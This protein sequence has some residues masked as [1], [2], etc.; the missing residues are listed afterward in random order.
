MVVTE[1]KLPL[2][3]ELFTRY[4]ELGIFVA[5]GAV[6]LSGPLS[7]TQ[8]AAVSGVLLEEGLSM[9]MRP[10]MEAFPW[11]MIGLLTVIVS[12]LLST[13]RGSGTTQAPLRQTAVGRGG[14]PRH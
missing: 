8:P 9:T 12:L 10:P 13:T 7:C 2:T 3:Q 5:S 1:E 4:S 14:R 11:K 6:M